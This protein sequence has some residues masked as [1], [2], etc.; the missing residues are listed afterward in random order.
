M[1]TSI[2]LVIESLFGGI[3]RRVIDGIQ[4][5]L[6]SLH[7]IR[8]TISGLICLILLS[9]FGVVS[10]MFIRFISKLIYWFFDDKTMC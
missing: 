10:F 2:L 8:G 7:L 3:I 5:Q 1:E 9:V 6:F 4:Q